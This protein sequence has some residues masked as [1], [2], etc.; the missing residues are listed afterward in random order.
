MDKN[1]KIYVAGHNGLVGSAITRAL[2]QLGY[3]NLILKN[4]SELDL[5]DPAVTAQFF[6][7]E[8]PEYVFL[9]AAKVGGIMANLTYPA[10]F[11]YEN[12]TVQNN[13]IH[14]A[15]K[16]SVKKLL[17]LGSSCI[18]PKNCPQPMREDYLLSSDLEPSNKPY[19]I[20]KISGIILCQS[21]NKQYGTNFISVMPT[22]LYGPSDKYDLN[23]SHVIPAMIIKFHRAKKNDE[24]EVVM[25]GT[26]SP[27]REF[28]YSDDLAQAC[29]YLMNGY[30]DSEIV[31]IGTGKD[32]SIKELAEL[33]KKIVGF[34]GEIKWDT[35][36]PDGVP[37]KLLDVTKLNNLGWNY[38]IELEQGLKVAY[39]WY[40]KNIAEK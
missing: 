21:Y 11:I 22:N 32:I 12:L 38:S 36:K 4:R 18:Y 1:S 35:T 5:L 29:I 33:I 14:N 10:D 31:N 24:N 37:K 3:S 20:S 27:K 8:K 25:W 28:L 17:F 16:N 40:V 7:K 26:G 2:I 34:N 15:Y 13:V 39:D 9:A 19:S 23:N 30:D 6:S